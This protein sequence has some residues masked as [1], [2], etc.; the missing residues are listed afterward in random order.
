[1]PSQLNG[2]AGICQDAIVIFPVVHDKYVALH[3]DD[4]VRSLARYPTPLG[5]RSFN[6]G[7]IGMKKGL[8]AKKEG[9]KK[10]SGEG[11]DAIP[12]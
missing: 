10:L 3:S 9:I 1:M 11:H 2:M 7:T 5:C 6:L 4:K 8:T 12:S